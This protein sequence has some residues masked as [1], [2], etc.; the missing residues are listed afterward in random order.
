MP[1]PFE[2]IEFDR[3]TNIPR[4][5]W[6]LLFTHEDRRMASWN[7]EQAIRD[8]RNPFDE[9]ERLWC[10][11]YALD[12]W[13]TSRWDGL[14]SLPWATYTDEYGNN[15]PYNR[16]PVDPAFTAFADFTEV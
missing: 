9:D 13:W 4:E 3:M 5:D 14:P 10:E 15:E 12:G 2:A 7:R 8:P 16:V 6:P 11:A 1:N